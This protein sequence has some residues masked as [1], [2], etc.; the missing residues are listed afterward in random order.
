[1]IVDAG[2]DSIARF[3]LL[4]YRYDPG[5]RERREVVVAAYD[6]R[7]EFEAAVR[8]AAGD[9]AARQ[10][11]GEAEEQERVSG[12]YKLAGADAEARRRRLA[13]RAIRARSR[14]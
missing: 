6:D 5:R 7:A 2:D 9:L 10:A 4:H 14:R 8:A 13:F 1:M 11:R 12:V 3:V